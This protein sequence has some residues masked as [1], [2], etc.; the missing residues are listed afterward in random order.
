MKYSVKRI[1]N[2][3]ISNYPDSRLAYNDK[4]GF[5]DEEPLR[6]CIDFFYFEK[7]HW[8]GC[9][10]PDMALG[11]IRDYLNIM[12]AYHNNYTGIRDVDTA[13]QMMR[14]DFKDKFNADDICDNRLLLCLAYAMGAAGFT[15]HGTS[16]GSAWLS[17]EGKMFLALLNMWEG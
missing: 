1:R 8:C 2:Y 3:I 9:G 17:D 7:L 11:C 6:E 5:S 16:I 13:Y 14:S 4:N 10:D 15:E 12:N